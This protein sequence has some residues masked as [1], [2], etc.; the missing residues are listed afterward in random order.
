MSNQVHDREC[1]SLGMVNNTNGR[2]FVRFNPVRH[3]EPRLRF[4]VG[5][6][7][8]LDSGL[9]QIEQP[10]DNEGQCQADICISL[11]GKQVVLVFQ[12]LNCIK[13]FKS[14]SECFKFFIY[15]LQASCQL[16]CTGRYQIQFGR[17]RQVYSTQNQLYRRPSD[18]KGRIRIL[19]KTIQSWIP[20]S[21]R[22]T[23]GI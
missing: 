1:M 10:L 5:V 19:L 22:L 8:L 3:L 17:T 2:Q 23:V 11:A 7:V 16:S 4:K 13:C 18:Q 21:P 9:G 14:S 20:R 12:Q 6:Y 15:Y